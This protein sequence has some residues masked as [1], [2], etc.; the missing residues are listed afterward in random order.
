MIQSWFWK[1]EQPSQTLYSIW[2]QP[3]FV[4]GGHARDCN[5]CTHIGHGLFFVHS[6]LQFKLAFTRYLYS[7]CVK[8][9]YGDDLNIAIGGHGYRLLLAYFGHR[10]IGHRGWSCLR[11]NTSQISK[12]SIFCKSIS[13]H[14]HQSAEVFQYRLNRS[15]SNHLG[16]SH[17]YHKHPKTGFLL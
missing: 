13:S 7:L 12:S 17:Y 14:S 5:N 6:L 9:M 4:A 16:Q 2:A 15:N 10:V 11:P 8:L 3:P 1:V